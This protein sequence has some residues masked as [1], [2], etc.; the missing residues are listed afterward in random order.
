MLITRNI[1]NPESLSSKG[2]RRMRL[3]LLYERTQIINGGKM[4][5]LMWYGNS[6]RIV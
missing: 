2:Y 5:D 1:L 4:C 6:M 3:E